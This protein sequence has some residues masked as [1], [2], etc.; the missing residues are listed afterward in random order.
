[1]KYQ[2]ML[3]KLKTDATGEVESIWI[4]L[5]ISFLESTLITITQ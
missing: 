4:E 2:V 1:M 3:E 5:K